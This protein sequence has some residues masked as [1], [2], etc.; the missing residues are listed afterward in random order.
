MADTAR[1][2]AIAL[3]TDALGIDAATAST[4][5]LGETDGWDSIGHM[6]L[7]LAIEQVVGNQLS[8]EEVV[9]LASCDDVV[10]ILS[11]DT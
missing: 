8:P 4:A 3:L 11:V 2:S 6:R 7:I 10:R 5:M 9:S 1:E